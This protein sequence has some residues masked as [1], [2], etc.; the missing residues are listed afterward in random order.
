MECSMPDFPVLHHLPE[1]AQTHVH[2]VGDAIQASHS[3]SPPSSPA[4]SLSQHQGL[5]QWVGSSHQVAKVLGLQHQSFQWIFRVDFLYGWLVWSPCSP[6]DSQESSTPQLWHGRK[7][8]TIFIRSFNLILLI[9]VLLKSS[10]SIS[11]FDLAWWF[12]T[13]ETVTKEFVR[14]LLKCIWFS[15]WSKFLGHWGL[16]KVYPKWET[17][18][19]TVSF[20]YEGIALVTEKSFNPSGKCT[21]S[22][23]NILIT[24][25]KW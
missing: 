14:F 23:K 22:N 4:L 20:Y 24:H 9:L 21:C 6:R 1:S 12:R 5:F 25:T 17:H 16:W 10:L 3:L 18:F 7:K 2:W 11:P 13:I 8:R 15:Q 19:P